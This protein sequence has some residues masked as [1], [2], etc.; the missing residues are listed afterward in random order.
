VA[1]PRHALGLHTEALVAERLKALGWRIVARRW[2]V[3]E[4]E[5]D[6]V[7]VDPA[8]TLVGVEV[9]GR[10][11]RRAGSALESVDRRH[12]GRL[13]AALV[14]YAVSEPTAHRELRIDLVAVD[15]IMSGWRVTRHAGIDGW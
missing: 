1:D 9:R 8:G 10:S 13:R 14:R 2:K 6:L 5:L 12:L 3:A 11:S 4:G 7:A 15:R